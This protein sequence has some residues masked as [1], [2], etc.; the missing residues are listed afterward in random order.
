M[1]KKGSVLV[2][3]LMLGFVVLILALNLAPAVKT[4]VD[5]SMNTTTDSRVGLNCSNDSISDYD[6]ATCVAVDASSFYFVGVLIFIGGAI[7][8]AR[9]IL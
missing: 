6:K 3:G 7:V 8:T 5:D 1:N 2:Y 4:F 9:F